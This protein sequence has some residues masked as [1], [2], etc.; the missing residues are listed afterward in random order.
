M[1]EFRPLSPKK[2]IELAETD[3]VEDAAR[4][5]RDFAACGRIKSYAVVVETVEPGGGRRTVRDATLPTEL[6][7]R[8]IEEGRDD[9]VW[10]GG[11]VRL[12][13]ADLIGGKPAV[14]ITAVGFN[15]SDLRR[16]IDR[17]L[18]RASKPT[19]R[20]ATRQ[21]AAAAPQEP[22]A[23]VSPATP[24]IGV[25]AIPAGAV[26]VT[27][28]QAMAALGLGRTMVDKLC[29]EGRLDRRRVGGRAL[30]TVAS[31]HALLA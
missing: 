10:P 11:T 2:A 13:G 22:E 31:I 12:P 7:Q 19:G 3:G 8:M 15:P 28:K 27:I 16:M 14:N 21:P 30:I 24:A 18:G 26:T 5:I 23:R 1:S 17:H 9:D 20:A 4:L 25:A 29:G 6:W